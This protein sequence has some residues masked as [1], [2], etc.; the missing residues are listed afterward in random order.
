MTKRVDTFS[1]M[2]ASSE[3]PW[4]LHVDASGIRLV[5]PAKTLPTR[6]QLLA[7]I[8]SIPSY[9]CSRSATGEAVSQ[10]PTYPTMGQAVKMIGGDGLTHEEAAA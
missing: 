2:M 1:K 5:T 10:G 3:H 7:D 4:F 6:D 8:M 9:S